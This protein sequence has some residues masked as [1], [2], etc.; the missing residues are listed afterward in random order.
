MARM[1]AL[2]EGVA[3]RA[4]TATN[5][6][7]ER[8][9][10]ASLVSRA[11]RLTPEWLR[12]AAHERREFVPAAEFARA[13]HEALAFL[14]E[15]V[16]D[17]EIGDY[18]EFG[19][20]YG[21]S[22]LAMYNK[23]VNLGLDHVRLF[24]FDSFEGLPEKTSE[25]DQALP[26]WDAGMFKADYDRVRRRLKDAGVDRNRVKLVKGWFSETLHPSA[27]DALGIQ[28]AGVIMMD[29]DFHS[30]TKVALEFCAPLI[31]DHAIVFFDDWDAGVGLAEQ[32]IGQKQAFAEFLAEH[33]SLAA[34][35][36]GTYSQIGHAAPAKIFHVWR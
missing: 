21:N 19:V 3:V 17:G 31:R 13:H 12:Q 22:L 33:P 16:G 24:G 8:A 7:L 2:A 30:S 4:A 15:R 28:K 35:E 9:G 25:G 5:R 23:L 36:V 14:R 27:A 32:G 11:R 20:F 34:A 1:K 10:L 6:V 29:C 18:L 26:G